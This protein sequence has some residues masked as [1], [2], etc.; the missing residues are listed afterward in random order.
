[1][2]AT[3]V[4]DGLRQRGV[5]VLTTY[6]AENLSCDDQDQLAFAF[7][8]GRVLFTMDDDF[9]A[10]HSEGRQHAG[11]VYLHQRKFSIGR[12]I[13]GLAKLARENTPAEFMGRLVYL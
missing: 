3:A 2:V 12:A 8:Q 13:H 6:E 5:D 1:M 4:A 10:M 9:L 7:G 11:L